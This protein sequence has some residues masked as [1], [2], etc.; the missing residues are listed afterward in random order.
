MEVFVYLLH[1]LN[2][3]NYTR[4]NHVHVLISISLY[5]ECAT[6]ALGEATLIESVPP[7]GSIGGAWEHPVGL[8]A[9]DLW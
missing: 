9:E 3:G 4:G 8:E 7:Q 6:I 2:E 5:F 1:F